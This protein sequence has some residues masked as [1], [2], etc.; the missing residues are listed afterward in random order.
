MNRIAKTDAVVIGR[1]GLGES[2]RLVTFYTRA[3]GK[4]RGVA[5]AARRPRSRFGSALELFTLGALVC[6]D[7]GRSELLRIDHFDIVHP[8]RGIREDLERFGQASWIV[9]CLSRLTADH[10]AFPALWSLF[11][12]ALKAVEGSEAPARPA[13]CFGARCV[14]MLGHRPRLDAC[15]GCGRSYPFVRPRLDFD[16]GGLVCEPCRPRTSAARP[17]SPIAVL[18]WQR[19]L[20]ATWRDAVS[21]PLG[22]A[23]PELAALLDTYVSRLIG[24]PTRTPPV[25]REMQRI[26]YTPVRSAGAARTDSDP[27]RPGS[28]GKGDRRAA[29]SDEAGAPV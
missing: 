25:L 27:A 11:V 18:A 19:V 6:F 7:T 28:E 4:V 17:V 23:E 24:Q 9:E 21:R 12:Q 3:M 15:V 8:F 2:D 10:D 22:R 5:R 1:R 29:A 20:G 16:S 26:P 14:A 13:I